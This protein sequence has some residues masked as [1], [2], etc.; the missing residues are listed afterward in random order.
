MYL[1]VLRDIDGSAF[2]CEI[3]EYFSMESVYSV[4]YEDGQ[5]EVRSGDNPSPKHNPNPTNPN[6]NPDTNPITLT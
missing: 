2:T 3:L 4:V 6:T 5:E 1:Q